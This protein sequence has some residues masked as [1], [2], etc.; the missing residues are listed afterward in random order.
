MTNKQKQCLLY[1]LG[2]YTGQIDGVFG[3]A[4]RQA[5]KD[6][7]ADYGIG[8]D[9]IFGEETK[10]RIREVIGNA[11]QP[12][13]FWE[14]I[15]YFRKEEFACKCGGRHCDGYPADISRSLVTAADR[16]RAHFGA[17]VTVSSGLRCEKHNEA[18]GGV[19][20]SRHKL[21]KAMDFCVKGQS[22]AAVLAYAKQQ[23]EIR[24]AYAID[25][26]YVHMD[27]L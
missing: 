27:V 23:P 12:A 15:Q 17:P 7:Q 19:A 22:A 18:V 16:L 9:G 2:Y 24:Y 8:V 10:K 6:F 14:G 4:S 13:N 11:E 3:P 1:C 26:N 20:G 25:S 21:G 5:T